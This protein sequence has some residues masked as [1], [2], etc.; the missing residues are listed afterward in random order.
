MRIQI[1]NARPEEK[2]LVV[3]LLK[4]ADLLTE[5]LPD[6]LRNFLLAKQDGM[7]VGV[8]G[9]ELFGPV[10]LL[11]SVAVN[12]THQGKGIAGQLVGQ[13]LAG[14]DERGL[15]EVYLITTTADHY[16]DRYGFEP[17]NREQVPEAIQLTRQFSG[18]CPSSAVV[19]K[20]NLT[21]Q[22]A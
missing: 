18:L 11:R 3:N 4:E 17:V 19:M 14:A 2:E 13:L 7:L 20:R 16:F 9:L 10:G 8:A 21:Q 15:R 12:P 6:G 5:D 1:D 22:T